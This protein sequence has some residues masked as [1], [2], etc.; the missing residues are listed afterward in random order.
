M[1]LVSGDDDG[2]VVTRPVV[3]QSDTTKRG[4][5]QVG[6]QRIFEAMEKFAGNSLKVY[7]ELLQRI[8]DET[9]AE[10]TVS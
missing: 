9:R 5:L 8:E 1:V 7:E 6:L 4:S 3:Y 10:N 2:F